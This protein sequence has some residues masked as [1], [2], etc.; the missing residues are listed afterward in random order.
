MPATEPR[1][2]PEELARMGTGVFERR[3]RP[4]LRPEDDGKF[5]ALDVQ[6]GD[7]EVDEVDYA[8]V[9]RLRA[10]N[11]AAEAWL[12]RIGQPAAYRIGGFP[13]CRLRMELARVAGR[14]RGDSDRRGD[15]ETGLS[16][17]A[18]WETTPRLCCWGAR[19][20]W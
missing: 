8:A 9:S 4:M 20:V 1:R 7:Y 17:A 12:S 3:V 6:T 14:G 10:R 5:V 15:P 2:T 11:P 16:R 18:S 19:S 13:S